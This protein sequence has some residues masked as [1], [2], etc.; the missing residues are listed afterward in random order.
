MNS[1]GSRLRIQTNNQDK[2]VFSPQFPI[3]CNF[4]SEG[5]EGGYPFLVGKFFHEFEVVPES[6]FPYTQ[7]DSKCS[8]VCDYT[9]KTKK[10]RVSKYGYLGGYYGATNEILMMKE[11]RANGP[12]PGN[13]RV[14]YT[15]NYYSHGIYSEK[16][17]KKNSDKLSKTTLVDKHLS[18][19]KVEHS[20]TL[21]GYGEENGVKYWIGMNTW[22][23]T[24]GED[25]FF[26]ILRGEN[27]CSIE[28]MGDYLQLEVVD[29]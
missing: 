5:C 1:L 6:C 21:V 16:D 17:L 18:W 22:G 10:Y 23:K 28:S 14:P 4:Y 29:R 7:S 20:I 2:T 25:G 26:R 12:M 3:S 15:F 13:I 9:K 8:N 24:F 11:I 19:E 27:E